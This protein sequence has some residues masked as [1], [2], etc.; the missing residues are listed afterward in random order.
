MDII[1]KTISIILIVLFIYIIKTWFK[2]V[3]LEKIKG[4][5][6]CDSINPYVI[7][8]IMEE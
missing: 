2:Q 1:F 4:L 7:L 8:E 5:S 3:T 6:G